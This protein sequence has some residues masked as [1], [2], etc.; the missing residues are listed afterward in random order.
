VIMMRGRQ[1]KKKDRQTYKEAWIPGEK[2]E[3]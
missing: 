1:K 3:M 2:Y